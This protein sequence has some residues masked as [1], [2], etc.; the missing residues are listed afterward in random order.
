MVA[1]HVLGC[2]PGPWFLAVCNGDR[3][4]PEPPC[5]FLLATLV[6]TYLTVASPLSCIYSGSC[7]PCRPMD[8]A[9]LLAS[10]SDE[11]AEHVA[12]LVQREVV[13]AVPICIKHHDTS[14]W[15]FYFRLAFGMLFF[16]EFNLADCIIWHVPWRKH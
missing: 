16:L 11:A 5:D 7:I 2:T 6:A 15:Q 13:E 4:G 1:R 14:L 8:L 3:A 10:C 9:C 12:A